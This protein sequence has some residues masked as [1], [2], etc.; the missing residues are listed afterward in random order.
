LCF[1]FLKENTR[2]FQVPEKVDNVSKA[3]ILSS[4]FVLHLTEPFQWVPTFQTCSV[5]GLCISLPICEVPQ[6]P[7]QHSCSASKHWCL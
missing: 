7:N 5:F 2:M 6:H 1:S 4:F 3:S